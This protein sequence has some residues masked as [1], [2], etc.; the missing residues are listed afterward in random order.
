VLLGDG[1]FA[2]GGGTTGVDGAASVLGGSASAGIELAIGWRIAVREATQL[3]LKFTGNGQLSGSRDGDSSSVDV[4]GAND[5]Y[6]GG[7][8]PWPSC[9][10]G[11]RCGAALAGTGATT[12][13]A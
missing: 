3:Q 1:V 9:A 8:P 2:A 11:S 4:R 13:R 7:P 5:R 10:D 12:R 6:Y